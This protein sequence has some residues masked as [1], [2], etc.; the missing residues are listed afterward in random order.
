MDKSLEV[1]LV[2]VSAIFVLYTAMIDPVASLMVAV[3]AIVCLVVYRKMFTKK[4]VKK[5][6]VIK[7]SI[8]KPTKKAV[9]SKRK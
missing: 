4:Q 8:N 5:V 6:A 7:K 3:V 9:R 2:I 1:A